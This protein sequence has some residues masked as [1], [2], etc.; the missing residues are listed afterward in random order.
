V[1]HEVKVKTAKLRSERVPEKVDDN[2]AKEEG[3]F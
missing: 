1:V 2:I 3:K